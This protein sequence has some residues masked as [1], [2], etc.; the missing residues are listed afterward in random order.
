MQNA[1]V[2]ETKNI[3]AKDYG[4]LRKIDTQLDMIKIIEWLYKG[5][6]KDP[7]IPILYMRC[8]FCGSVDHRLKI[9]TKKKTFRCS[10]CGIEGGA[11]LFVMLFKKLSLRD[12]LQ[13]IADNFDIDASVIPRHTLINQV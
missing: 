3:Q 1:K 12:A 13:L 8:P 4:F 5:Y 10:V 9:D 6:V 7:S 2:T 11:V